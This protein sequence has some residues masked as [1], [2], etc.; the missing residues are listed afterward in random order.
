MRQSWSTNG[1]DTQLE[2]L[3]P[4]PLAPNPLSTSIPLVPT[5]LA[6]PHPQNLGGPKQNRSNFFYVC[7]S[8]TVPLIP[9][10]TAKFDYK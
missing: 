5:P 4:T 1:K 9:N 7:H 2:I 3:H 6:H 8:S 10:Q